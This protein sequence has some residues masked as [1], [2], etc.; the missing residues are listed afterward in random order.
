[1]LVHLRSE[2]FKESTLALGSAGITFP[3]PVEIDSLC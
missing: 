1:M 2:M 3:R